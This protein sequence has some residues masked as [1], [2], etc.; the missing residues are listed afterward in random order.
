[1]ATA[2]RT[3]SV[4]SR[5]GSDRG[6]V[7]RVGYLY[8][9][10]CEP[11]NLRLAFCRAARGK[12]DRRE[13]RAYSAALGANL[14]ALRAGLITETFP[15]GSYR[16]FPVYDPKE[17]VICAAAFA[18]RV[19]HHAIM[20]V[21][22]PVLER[23]AVG[24]SYACRRGKGLHAA[25]AEAH[26]MVRRNGWY[27]KLDVRHYFESLSHA[28]A[29]AAYQRLIKDRKLLRL[30]ARIFASYETAPGIGLPIGNLISQHTAN[31]VLGRCDHFVKQQ[32]RIRY[33]LR[34]MDD[35]VLFGTDREALARAHTA[36]T[37]WVADELELQLKPPQLN[38]CALGLPWL[39][40]RVRPGGITLGPRARRRFRTKM[41]DIVAGLGD[42][43]LAEGEAQRRAAAL[44]AFAA[45]ADS[46]A[47]RRATLRH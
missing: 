26:G 32:L 39:G 23:Y 27:L 47:F 8:E 14:A 25:V 13:V 44:C 16:L 37:S 10:I 43:R 4:R 12:R 20:N 19:L 35:M 21:C 11:D 22:E 45:V 15:V 42:G 30:L 33:Y 38:R 34:Y 36:M 28:V 40:F 9:A 18:E 5:T 17:R 7:Q 24:A 3:R 6:T 31:L 41:D 46:A 29:L 1:M 2:V